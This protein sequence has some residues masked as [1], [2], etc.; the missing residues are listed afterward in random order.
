VNLFQ[1]PVGAAISRGKGVATPMEQAL[2]KAAQEN[3]HFHSR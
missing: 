2:E 1:N 3:S